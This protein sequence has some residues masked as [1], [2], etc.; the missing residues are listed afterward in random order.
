MKNARAPFGCMYFLI[1][2]RY[3]I[4]D[5]CAERQF[6]LPPVTARGRDLHFN[7]ALESGRP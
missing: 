7:P 2:I 6:R 3:P 5:A 4:S 1:A